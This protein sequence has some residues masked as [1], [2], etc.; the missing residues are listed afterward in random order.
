[1]PG[2]PK[3]LKARDEFARF[4]EEFLGEKLGKLSTV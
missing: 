3:K 1:M 4:T 2:E